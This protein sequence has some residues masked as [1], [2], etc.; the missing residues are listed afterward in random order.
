MSDCPEPTTSSA[1]ESHEPGAAAN[2]KPERTKYG[3]FGISDNRACRRRA[4]KERRKRFGRFHEKKEKKE[5][6]DVLQL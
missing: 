1:Q 5:K 6:V 4:F 2:R 3:N